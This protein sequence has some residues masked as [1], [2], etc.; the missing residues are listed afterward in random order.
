MTHSP[1]LSPNH[2]LW[3]RS[4]HVRRSEMVRF[5]CV[6]C[7]R[8]FCGYCILSLVKPL[9]LPFRFFVKHLYIYI[10]WIKRREETPNKITTCIHRFI[11][12]SA[13]AGADLSVY[14][15]IGAGREK[16]AVPP[17]CMYICMY[18]AYYNLAQKATKKSTISNLAQKR[19]NKRKKQKNKQ[20][21]P[22]NFAKILSV[23]GVAEVDRCLP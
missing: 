17:R 13:Q 15:F 14:R 9:T 1:T 5:F 8:S 3:V 12:L 2:P 10:T 6:V 20:T 18:I 7:N 23:K 16:P 11:G 19:D 21:L 22:S 4:G